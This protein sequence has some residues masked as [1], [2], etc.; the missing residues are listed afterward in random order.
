MEFNPNVIMSRLFGSK[1]IALSQFESIG[2][3]LVVFDSAEYQS[4]SFDF[5]QFQMNKTT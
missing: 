3:V 5:I 1:R 2:T 4:D